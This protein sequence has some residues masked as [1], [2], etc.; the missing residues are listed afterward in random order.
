MKQ[1][2]ISCQSISRIYQNDVLVNEKMKKSY[3]EGE[4]E[5]KPSPEPLK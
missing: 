3:A 1:D 4:G 2:A 5:S